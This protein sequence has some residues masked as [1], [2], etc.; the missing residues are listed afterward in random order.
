MSKPDIRAL[1][2]MELEQAACPTTHE[3]FRVVISQDAFD[4]MVE[5]GNEHTTVEVGGVLVG[6]ALVDD[7][8]PYVLVEAIIDALH[9]KQG[10]TDMTFTHEAWDHINTV[11]DAKHEDQ[12]IVGWYHTHPGFGLF[13]S[14]QDLFIQRSFFDLPFQIAMVYDPL[15]REHG[16]F[17]WK[18]GEP[19]RMRH[20]WVGEKAHLWDGDRATQ[21]PPQKKKKAKKKKDDD[22]ENEAEEVVRRPRGEDDGPPGFVF[23]IIVA[24]VAVALGVAGGYF[25]RARGMAD[26]EKAIQQSLA[27]A[28]AEGAMDAVRL[29]R[30]ELLSGVQ[31]A[32][33][34]EKI[35]RPVA[36]V[37]KGLTGTLEKITPAVPAVD[38]KTAKA[39]PKVKITPQVALANLQAARSG[40]KAAVDELDRLE[41][42]HLKVQALINGLQQE[43]TFSAR[44]LVGLS[45]ETMRLRAGLGE[46]YSELANAA[47]ARGDTRTAQRLATAAAAFNPAGRNRY[48]K[49]MGADPRKP[50][51]GADK[52]PK[53]Q[54]R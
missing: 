48:R 54:K 1:S 19:W 23:T 41:T 2:E 3:D 38:T 32:L 16:C 6:R 17:S 42:N 8:G 11:M 50:G 18:E 44:A 47:A 27:L 22:D 49:A 28:K 51:K 25:Y 4:S 14:E 36:E 26:R 37:R 45:K 43:T 40:I 39:A 20:Y 24:L 30:S 46:V 29:L 10:I 9:S 5:H 12:K 52:P 7:N 13:L 35:W 21:A 15:S 33:N 31:G 34:R 53:E